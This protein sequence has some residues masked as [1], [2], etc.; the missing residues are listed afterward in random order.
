MPR[1]TSFDPSHHPRTANVVRFQAFLNSAMRRADLAA[2]IWPL[3]VAI[4]LASEAATLGSFA[5]LVLVALAQP[6]FRDTRGDWLRRLDLSVTFLDRDGHEIGRRGI[7]HEGR[8]ALDTLPPHLVDAVVAT[9]DR[10][11]FT[12]WGIDPIGLARALAA[13]AEAD[14]IVQGGSTITQQ[15]AKNLF[16]S[17][18]R[19]LERKIEEAFLAV[20]LECRFTKREL[21]SLYLDRAYMGAGTF[22]VRAAAEF[23]FGKR[24]EDVTLAEGAMLAGLF[25]APSKFAPH[26]N[27]EAATARADEVLD[28]MVRAG[29]ITAGEAAAA[30]GAPAVAVQHQPAAAPDYYLDAAFHE[31]QGLDASGRLGRDP[32]LTVGTPL[33]TAIQHEAEVA[34]GRHLDRDGPRYGVHQAAMV[35]MTPQGGLRALVGGRDYGASQFDRAT[36]A[37]RQPGSAFKP[38]VYVTALAEGGYRPDSV[39]VDSPVCIGNWCPANY[40]HSFA[41]A[42]PLWVALARSINTVAVKLS[43]GIGETRGRTRIAAA[44]QDG[45]ARIVAYAHALGLTTPLA[46][47]PSLPLGASEVRLVE[48]TSAYAALANGGSGARA[49]AVAEVRNS[50]DD[51]VYRHDRDEAGSREAVAPAIAAAMNMMLAKVP[52]VGTG[53]RAA[54]PGRPSAGKTGTTNDYRDAWYVGFTGRLVAGVWFGNDDFSPTHGMTGGTLPAAAW[55]DVMAFAERGLSPAPIPGVGLLDEATPVARVSTHGGIFEVVPA[56]LGTASSRHGFQIVGASAGFRE[57]GRP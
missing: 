48:L 55:H 31:I 53:R 28:R 8:V 27:P 20:W 32:V 18:E 50:H 2:R 17:G 35:V 21:L 7:R 23:Y 45:R 29:F 15:L 36:D 5:G 40:G 38:F 56:A 6:A 47:T 39:V 25:K 42:I 41:G 22:G 46:D 13:N 4:G 51:L 19:S 34:I 24:I 52:Q 43:I 26:A 3:R 37:L 54:L 9:E 57:I 12:H 44:A 16:L 33:D 1:R 30:K 11:F 49:F 10:R 14:G